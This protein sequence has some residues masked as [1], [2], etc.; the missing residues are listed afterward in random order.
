MERAV[1]VPFHAKV[2]NHIKKINAEC[3][4]KLDTCLS[5]AKENGLSIRRTHKPS[6]ALLQRTQ[7]FLLKKMAVLVEASKLL[8]S[9]NK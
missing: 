2:G 8:R 5:N 6:F 4:K 9:P 3:K 1:E 7:T